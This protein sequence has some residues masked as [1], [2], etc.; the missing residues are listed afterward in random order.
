M[1]PVVFLMPDIQKS[2][3]KVPFLNQILF[4]D[5]ML[6]SILS[7]VIYLVASQIPIYGIVQKQSAD[8]LYW[9]RAILASN[10]GSLMELGISP[11]ITAGMVV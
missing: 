8:P 5:K 9:M 4:R 3:Y 11:I 6:W 1:R 7:L 2:Q 10:R